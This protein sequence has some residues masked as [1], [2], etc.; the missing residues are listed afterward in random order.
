MAR[1]I[2]H[3]F[4]S[5][6]RFPRPRDEED[7]QRVRSDLA[8][9]IEHGPTCQAPDHAP[10][11]RLIHSPSALSDEQWSRCTPGEVFVEHTNNRSGE[12]RTVTIRRRWQ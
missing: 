7:P 2:L 10:R 11:L 3:V 6:T 12:H 4:Q 1:S 5:N 8:G 9:A